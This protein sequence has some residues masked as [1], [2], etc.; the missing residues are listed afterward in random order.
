MPELVPRSAGRAIALA[1]GLRRLLRSHGF[2]SLPELPLPHGRR[3]DLVAFNAD[4]EITIVEI[5]SSEADYRADGKWRDY[6]A[7]C[8]RFYFGVASDMPLS[9]FPDDVGL[10]VADS[11]GGEILRESP[12]RRAA[13]ASRRAVLLRFALAAAD[14]LH[15]HADPTIAAD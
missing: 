10:I 7:Y 14:R 3:A 11:Y 4:G 13:P 15:R 1:R 6:L 12:L 2:S 5:K 9:L 8:D